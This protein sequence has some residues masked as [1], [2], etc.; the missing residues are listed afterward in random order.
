MRRSSLQLLRAVL[1]IA[2]LVVWVSLAAALP[3]SAQTI[4]NPSFESP[5]VSGYAYEAIDGWTATGGGT[6]GGGS[7]GVGLDSGGTFA[8][9]GVIPD[10]SQIAFL[11]TDGSAPTTL[12]QTITG[13]KVG[14]QYVISFYYNSRAYGDN[15]ILNV[16]FGGQAITAPQTVTPVGGSNPYNFIIT[17]AYTATGESADLVFAVSIPQG[18]DASAVIDDVTIKDISASVLY[19]FNFTTGGNSPQHGLIQGP[20]GSLYGVTPNG[21]PR[22]TGTVFQIAPDGTFHSLHQFSDQND[23]YFPSAKLLLVGNQLFGTC[24]LGGDVRYGSGGT[25]FVIDLSKVSPTDN[26]AGFAVLHYF[27]NPP[28][29]PDGSFPL[30]ALFLA[31]DGDLYGT[32]SYSGAYPSGTI[33]QIKPDNSGRFSVTRRTTPSGTDT[34][35]GS[36]TT[37]FDFGTGVGL[38]PYAGVVQGPDGFLYG[39]TQGGGGPFSLGTVYKVGTDGQ[40]FTL[41]HALASD[42]AGNAPEG[43]APQSVPLFA[44]DG[45]LYGTTL[46]GGQAQ[47]GTVFQ[48]KPG[49]D[50]VFGENAP[51]Q[52]IHDFSPIP[53]G[54]NPADG[55][56]QASDGN[57]YGA[58]YFGGAIG[59]VSD[60]SIFSLA[61]SGGQSSAASPFSTIFSFNDN[62]TNDGSRIYDGSRVSGPLIQGRDG[63]LYGETSQGGPGGAG[64]VFALDVG[65]PTPPSVTRVAGSF[66]PPDTTTGDTT[67]VVHGAG[68]A[69]GDTVA[70]D[71]VNAS[72]TSRDYSQADELITVA[73]APPLRAGAHT[74]VVADTAP[75][76]RVSNPVA[77]LVTL[78]SPQIIQIT[79]GGGGAVTTADTTL[80]IHGNSFALGDIVSVGNV[81]GATLTSVILDSGSQFTVTLSQPL[82]AGHHDVTVTHA[83][84]DNRVSNT[85]DLEVF[86]DA[87]IIS[88]VTG[89]SSPPAVTT[90]DTTLIVHGTNFA[91]TDS[92]VLAGTSASVTVAGRDLSN[93]ADEQITVTLSQALAAGSYTAEVPHGTPDTSTP[94]SFTVVAAAAPTLTSTT[95]RVL[96]GQGVLNISGTGFVRTGTTRITPNDSNVKLGGTLVISFV[97]STQLT[98]TFSQPLPAGVYTLTE[99]NP[100]TKTARISVYVLA[101]TS[102]A[103]DPTGP[104]VTILGAGF[105]PG[106]AVIIGDASNGSVILPLH[107]TADATQIV[108]D[109]L[110]PLPPGSHTF[111]VTNPDGQMAGATLKVLAPVTGLEL[112]VNSSVPVGGVILKLGGAGFSGTAN[113]MQI[114]PDPNSL[115]GISAPTPRSTGRAART[116]AATSDSPIIDHVKVQTG[117]GQGDIPTSTFARIEGSNFD[118][119]NADYGQTTV[120]VD[121]LPYTGN[122]VVVHDSNIITV[123]IGVITDNATHHLSVTNPDGKSSQ[124]VAF[125]VVD[126]T[127]NNQG[128]FVA[129]PTTSY[130]VSIQES[131]LVGAGTSIGVTGQPLLGSGF[132]KVAIGSLVSH[133]GGSLVSHD[134]GSIVAQGGGNIV[135][136]GGGNLVGEDGSSIV[137]QGG[138]NIVAQGGGNFFDKNGNRIVAQ[139]GGNLITNDGATVISND[140]GSFKVAGDNVLTGAGGGPSG[141]RAFA[142]LGASPAA[143]SNGFMDVT[144]FVTK[145]S[146]GMRLLVTRYTPGERDLILYKDPSVTVTPSAGTP[147]PVAAVTAGVVVTRGP[148]TRDPRTH[149]PFQVLTLTNTGAGVLSG[150][151]LLAM[152]G[153]PAGVTVAA[154]AGVVAGSPAVAAPG[155]ALAP[156]ASVKVR[157]DFSDPTNAR[158]SYGVAVYAG[159]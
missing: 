59:G 125:G 132:Q 94:F 75:G 77:F 41:L 129:R 26:A 40:G 78:L 79:R 50:G 22:G 150:P 115:A 70:I 113:L 96:N 89:S 21:T 142:P 126:G 110:N 3:A 20:D 146:Q 62:G 117:L 67:L 25:M 10:G 72:V 155:S 92:V 112:T 43:A 157:V 101:V 28:G 109:L 143:T 73:L 99:T 116:P 131:S 105:S 4:T 52:L 32:T 64:T 56:I 48:I 151:F 156:G 54:S 134:G 136:Q 139:G 24:Y 57:L 128:Q 148:V 30:G 58:T 14:H 98:A 88:A 118:A 147:T 8:N 1:L 29:Q 83:A 153:L 107:I 138:G 45:F 76:V 37:I 46:Y 63:R 12:A 27:A 23:G 11:Q 133:D 121:G 51:F 69:A 106:A 141:F 81:G 140:G 71:G 49:A 103:D 152:T 42:S 84:P 145:G 127:Y 31:S 68:F 17:S 66:A 16:S 122:G 7:H 6:I 137:A 38:H 135:A 97:S 9:N 65:L 80:V 123:F 82:P 120:T 95:Y 87:P 159:L 19:G 18:G 149:Q 33:F 104:S 74:V 39:T 35:N 124:T 102:A 53:A 90:V 130:Q 91:A 44:S 13:L 5:T 111:T 114:N 93:P 36:Y 100:D 15:P 144:L 85:Y 34:F 108:V 47:G 158:F 61:A 119:S 55:L 86:S 60:G 2:A 154:Q